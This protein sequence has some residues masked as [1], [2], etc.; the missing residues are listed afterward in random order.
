MPEA[1][2]AGDVDV[3]PPVDGHV[4]LS[5][6]PGRH[7]PGGPRAPPGLQLPAERLPGEQPCQISPNL[8]GCDSVLS[9]SSIALGPCYFCAM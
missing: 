6:E 3:S 8:V 9:S 1:H 5:N 4:H 7:A 2:F